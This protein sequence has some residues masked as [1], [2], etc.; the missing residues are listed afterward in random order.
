MLIIRRGGWYKFWQIAILVEWWH[1]VLSDGYMLSPPPML[2]VLADD[3]VGGCGC[4]SMGV[5]LAE[6]WTVV[7]SSCWQILVFVVVLARVPAH[8][9]RCLVYG[10]FYSRGLLS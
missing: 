9:N 6:N 2:A 5:V 7:F 4:F 3:G 8:S 10:T 1:K